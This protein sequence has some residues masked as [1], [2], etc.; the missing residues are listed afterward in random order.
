VAVARVTLERFRLIP[1]TTRLTD[2]QV[3]ALLPHVEEV[4]L[5]EGEVLFEQGDPAVYI[6]YVEQGTVAEV[7]HVPVLPI[8]PVPQ[9][10]PGGQADPSQVVIDPAQ[11]PPQ[12]VPG[13][14]PTIKEVV[15]RYAGQGEYLGRYAL[16]T[17]QP[18]RISAVAEVDSIL[19][20]IPLRHMQPILFAHDD[21]RTWFFRSDIATRLRAVPL[22]MDLDDW[23]IYRLADATQVTQHAAGATIFE[24]GDE[25]DCLYIVDQGQVIEPLPPPNTPREGWPRYFGPGNFFGHFSLQQGQDRLTTTRTRLPTRLFCI[26]E[27]T[28]K[29]L[30][31]DRTDDIL[32]E[33]ARV[34]LP[35][36]LKAI[37]QFSNLTNE[38]LHLLSGYVCLEYHRPGDIVAR[39]GEPA[40]SL[41]MMIEGEAVVRLQFGRGQPRTVTHFKG[42]RIGSRPDAS[43]GNYFGAHALF[44]EELRGATVEVTRP[45]VWLVLYRDDFEHFLRDT[46]MAPADLARRTHPDL[47]LPFKVRRHWLVPVS[48]ILPL[49]LLMF[50]ILTF[51]VN[52]PLSGGL[53]VV[54]VMV[55]LVIAAA[56]LYSIVDW[57][58]DSL[59]VTARSVI[60]T[61]R[62]LI[63]K[64]ER[65]ELPLQQIQNVNTSVNTLGRWFG[66]G[67]LLINS[68]G[69]AGQI[70]FTLAPSPDSVREK[71]LT[72]AASEDAQVG[73]PAPSPEG[74]LLLPYKVRKH[75]VVP[76]SQ[77]VPLAAIMFATVLVMGTGT[78]G[79]MS[80]PLGV[81]GLVVF[82]FWALY[83][84]VDWLNDTYE[85]TTRA[86]IHTEKKL[87]FSA[88][89][90]EIPLQQIQNVTIYVGVVGRYL[91]FGNV[92]IDT[93]AAKGRIAFTTIPRPAHV[94]LL[95]QQASAQA[96]SGLTVQRRES[97]RQQ[98]EDQFYPERLK[99]SI[100]G[101]VLIPPEEPP[102][103]GRRR[104]FRGFRGL[105][106]WFPQFEIRE[107]GQVIWRKHWINLLQRTGFQFLL[108]LLSIYLVAAFALASLTATLGMA[109]FVLPPVTWLGFQGWLFLIV[110][111]LS[112]LAA[113]WFIYQYVDW[114]NDIYIVT[115]DEVIDVERELAIFPFFFFYTE[116]RKQ[117]SL[118]NVQYVD[119]KIPNPLA[120][121]LNYGNVIVQT[122][123]AEGTLDFLWVSKPRNV[124]AEILRRLTAFE[125]REREREFQ[126]R[127]ADM[128]RWFDTYRDVIDQTGLPKG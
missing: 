103:D 13:A 106:G 66:A 33:Q 93:A 102:E 18:F 58:D 37:P 119:L 21:W 108:F 44:E 79:T 88:E 73:G 35:G 81:F 69:P 121:I 64:L 25:A 51:M 59:E 90:Y 9:G 5:Y 36:R 107:E 94:Q 30:L 99:P 80:L 27:Q 4:S 34:D 50:L 71:I 7:E 89:R 57:M 8:P 63:F 101:T 45:S 117:A 19:L 70:L 115:D 12:G 91:G 128:P 86:V 20:A 126:E 48:Q 61:E 28:I 125:E 49:A 56:M 2:E 52:G 109:A 74:D 38:Y 77:L 75:W 120:M 55:L 83:R 46:G 54:G 72:A 105:R 47:D 124:H 11:P 82:G 26:S 95:I 118:T 98:L 60:H 62:K 85:V 17:G 53:A 122:A 24:P 114:R 116:S 65:T 40:T 84:F 127:W 1:L 112:A 15:H 96:R 67:N 100:P 87:F 104:R 29:Q 41:M 22:F 97:I 76:F 78:L 6:Y 92:N 123:G 10:P 111:F 42:H 110:L 31:A 43:E 32:Q 16:V 113:L 39:Q 23:D 14:P 3:L 68:A